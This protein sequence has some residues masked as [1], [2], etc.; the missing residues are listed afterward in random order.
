MNNETRVFQGTISAG[1]VGSMQT[2]AR[3]KSIV[4]Q[5]LVQPDVTQAAARIAAFLPPRDQVRQ[6]VAIRDFLV[7]VF[8]FV[9]DP[10]G[11]ELLRTPL[12][13]LREIRK[14]GTTAGDCDDAAILGAALGLAVGIPAVF[15]V[16]SFRP[17][18]NFAHVFT[19]LTPRNG[20]A[21]DLDV[22]KPAQ[23][24]AAPVRSQDYPV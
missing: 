2:L 10:K 9:P 17:G 24:A 18:A 16:I 3:M 14:G 12:F 22:T 21:I 13:Q 19:I 23:G 15:R 5:S 20:R 4:R 7:R 8:R 6:A 1:Y 11:V